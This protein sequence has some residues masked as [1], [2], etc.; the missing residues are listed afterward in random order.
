MR[1]NK[2]LEREIRTSQVASDDLHLLRKKDEDNE[3]SFIIKKRRVAVLTSISL[4]ILLV[5]A[6]V[7]YFIYDPAMLENIFALIF[8]INF[9]FLILLIYCRK[10]IKKLFDQQK[11]N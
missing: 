9:M 7:L 1:H 5:V 6:N 11:L 4:L 2:D 8:F 10:R 3:D